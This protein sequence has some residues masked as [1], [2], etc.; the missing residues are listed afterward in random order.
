[1]SAYYK[2]LYANCIQTYIY[3]YI[4]ICNIFVFH[5]LTT[6]AQCN[7]IKSSTA[8]KISLLINTAFLNTQHTGIS[9]EERAIIQ[10][11]LDIFYGN[12]IQ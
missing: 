12:L 2:N 8:K 7:H 3:I 6:S 9:R 11:I 5:A 4:Y 1:M 10:Y